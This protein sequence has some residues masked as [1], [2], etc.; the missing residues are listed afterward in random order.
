MPYQAAEVL[1]RDRPTT[2]WGRSQTRNHPNTDLAYLRLSDD[3]IEL[4][5]S[6]LEDISL[7]SELTT[8]PVFPRLKADL[9]IYVNGVAGKYAIA[10]AVSAMTMKQHNPRLANPLEG[11]LQAA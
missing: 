5:K 2:C 4:L 3:M 1:L 11:F 7:L 6:R 9:E 8:H 10:D